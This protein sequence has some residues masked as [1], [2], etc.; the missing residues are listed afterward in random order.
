MV[1]PLLFEPA[2]WMTAFWTPRRAGSTL[3]PVFFEWSPS[4]V[5]PAKVNE[6]LAATLK[7]ESRSPSPWIIRLEAAAPFE[8]DGVS[9]ADGGQH[10]SEC[11]RAGHGESIS[12]I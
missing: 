6:A 11:D 1:A 7:I 3:M 2:F 4:S 5:R 8:G 10:R 9:R 12:S